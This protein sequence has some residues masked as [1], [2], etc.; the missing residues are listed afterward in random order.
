MKSLSCQN[1]VLPLSRR[2]FFAGSGALLLAAGSKANA[3]GTTK[4]NTEPIID[5]HQHTNYAG[6]SQELLLAHQRKMGITTTILLPAGTPSFGLSTHNGKTNGLQAKCGGNDVCYDFAKEYPKEFLYGSNEVPDLPDAVTEIEKYLKLG[7]P[8]IGELKFGV[9][10]DSAEMQKIYELA[11][12][13]DVPVLM[14]WQFEMF[15]YNFENFHK[16]LEKYPKVNFIGHAQTWW[17]NIDKNHT[18][19]KVLYP[20]T[21]VT[22]GGITD[23][24]LRDYPN[25]YGDMSAGSGLLAMT[26]DED[27]YREFLSRHQDKLLYGS[28]CDD[29]EGHGEKCQGAQTIAMIRKLAPSKEI[30]RKILFE[31]AKKLFKI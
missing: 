28:D 11:Q 14:H 16:M 20:K 8:V 12:T 27:H 30:E 25:M 23:R 26:R 13:Y 19:Q 9:A 24:L 17:A 21:K 7:A 10:C 4:Q 22:P 3:F 1:K 15:N 5:I 2:D 6:R 29:A 31:N 18:D